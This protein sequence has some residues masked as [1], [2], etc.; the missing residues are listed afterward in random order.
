[1]SAA[2]LVALDVLWATP[3]ARVLIVMA[4]I[5]LVVVGLEWAGH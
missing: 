5:Y 1:V 2:L 3:V 4:A